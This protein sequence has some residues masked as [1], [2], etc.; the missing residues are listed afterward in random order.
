MYR[1]IK[2]FL[3]SIKYNLKN[4]YVLGSSF[5]IGVF[6]MVLN[7]TSFYI[8]WYLF[9]S[10]TGDINGWGS[11]DI[12]GML[13]ISTFCFGI[14][15]SFFYGVVKMPS[16]VTRGDFDAVLLS[17]RLILNRLSGMN[18]SITALG[19]LFMGFGVFVWYGIT[20]LFS[21]EQWLMFLVVI[22]LG[23]ITFLCVRILVSLISFY[24]HDGEL[25]SGQIFKLFLRPGLY[26]G[27]MFP[28]K[29]KLFF[30]T[31]IPSLLTSTV[32]IDYIKTNSINIF[33]LSFCVTLFWLL[34][35]VI[36]FKISIKRYESGNFLR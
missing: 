5:W 28:S 27:S 19:D 18:F 8:I 10:A 26:P 12:F 13:G 15:N 6:S 4:A 16:I 34:I 31:V 7:N 30:M 1:E 29:M 24:I 23:V 32:P 36:I 33:L 2:Y 20:K 25:I 21:F 35:T 14:T 9:I 22:F 3:V 17:P 11:Y